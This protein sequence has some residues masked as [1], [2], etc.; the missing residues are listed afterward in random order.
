MIIEATD[1]AINASEGEATIIEA[2][3]ATGAPTPNADGVEYVQQTVSVV[4]DVFAVMAP[5]GK[6]L[7]PSLKRVVNDV[8]KKIPDQTH[9]VTNRD[10]NLPQLTAT[11]LAH[12]RTQPTGHFHAGTTSY[13]KMLQ[14]I[15]LENNVASCDVTREE[16][17]SILRGIINVLGRGLLSGYGESQDALE[18]LLRMEGVIPKGEKFHF[19]VFPGRNDAG[20][21]VLYILITSCQKVILRPP[22][23]FV[24]EAKKARDFELAFALTAGQQW[25]IIQ[26]L[27]ERD[28]RWANF[29]MVHDELA[30]FANNNEFTPG[31]IKKNEKLKSLVDHIFR[32]L[33]LLCGSDRVFNMGLDI[34]MK[35]FANRN[36]NAFK[37]VS[38]TKEECYDIFPHARIAFPSQTSLTMHGQPVEDWSSLRGFFTNQSSPLANEMLFFM[39][40][41]GNSATHFPDDPKHR[42]D[43]S[44]IVMAANGEAVGNIRDR[45]TGVYK[46]ALGL[47]SSGAGKILEEKDAATKALQEEVEASAVELERLEEAEEQANAQIAQVM[48]M[49]KEQQ[50]IQGKKKVEE[51]KRNRAKANLIN[52]ALC[53]HGVGFIVDDN[54]DIQQVKQSKRLQKKTAVASSKKT[55]ADVSSSSRRRA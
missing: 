7:N 52:K 30:G 55:G 40:V 39:W 48:A 44:D 45:T 24:G 34:S 43:F 53:D 16:D 19:M 28:E 20:E 41:L 38:L 35:A 9:A 47:L 17:M 10:V 13:E 2:N 54:I 23:P 4:H 32:G 36:N 6:A 50:S 26:E 49:F 51:K 8:M 5:E 22:G 25:A 27:D 21:D 33:W 11:T 29:Q 31:K 46:N 1:E 15:G 12:L 18:F 14:S 42:W 3:E 37:G